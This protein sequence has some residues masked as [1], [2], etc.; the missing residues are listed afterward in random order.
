MKIRTVSILAVLMS[1][2][3][4]AQQGPYHYPQVKKVNQVD[5][6]FGTKIADPFRW[7]E[8]SD[9]PDTRA[10]IDAQNALTFG[11]LKQIPERERISKRLW[12]LW[13]YERYGIPSREGRWYVFTKNTGKQNQNVVYRAASLD[14]PAEVLIDPNTLS[15]DGTVALGPTAFSD[16]GKF[17]AYAVSAAGSDW[18]EWRVRD[19]A[20]GQDL[21]DV[22]KWSKF[23]GASWLKD[24]SG[25]YYGRYEAP[26][27]ANLLQA[28]NKNQKLYFHAVGTPQEKDA[29]VYERP[30]KPDWMFGGEVTDDGRYLLL[31]QTEGTENKNR[32]FVRDL[33]DPNGRIEP[34]LNEFD[35]AYSVVGNDADSFYVLT[36]NGA[37]RYKL[38]AISR[39]NPS[40]AAWRTIIPEAP[41]TDVLDGVTMV[42]DRFVTS[43]MTDAHTA[44]RIYSRA[45]EKLADL[46]LPAIGTVSAFSG[47][48]SHTEGFYAFTSYT[49]PT[50]VYRY[51]FSTGASTVFKRPAV[52]FDAAKYETVQVFYPS[53]DGTK[54]PMF[55]T[56]R[57]GL[58][59][60]GQ[61]PTYL[62]GYGGFNSPVTPSFSPAMA[63]WLEMGGIYAVANLRGGGEYG[64]AWYDA[65][66]L[67]NKQNVFDDFIAAAEYLIRERYTS[68]PKLAIAGGSNGG[69]LV[70]ACMTQRPDLFGAALPAVGVMDMLRYHKFTIGWAWT[71]DYGDPDTKDGFDINIK[72]SP[73]HNIRPG[74]KYPAT[75]VTT[76]DHDDRVVPAHSF[77][78]I[79]TL[80]AAQAGPA[81]IL[82]RIETKAGHGAG[83]P[84]DKQIEERTD[85]FGFLVRELT[86]ALPASFGQK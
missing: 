21:P 41:G 16:D 50:T 43:W 7:L 35:A 67:K 20:T 45:G 65:G 78:F 56:Y 17:M 68:T 29:L 2:T 25:F 86:I 10:W 46:A 60:T 40:P 1:V 58:A 19:V 22:I 74:T 26:K 37:P 24:G 80:Q 5:D 13:D 11:Y 3:L 77:K 27:D 15:K 34:F 36:N 73:L 39:S 12:A 44:M 48:R 53:K 49:Y 70:G 64:Q 81:P 59:K 66:R 14:A 23:S 72:Y 18:Q 54:I 38:V 42:N 52:D 85:I 30:D 47:R 31:Y 57:K 62:Y 76:A 69:L 63:A 51:D 71:S 75:L 32:I 61:N 28:V 83:K 82:I 9:A 55:L 33:K 79:A 4:A 8:D 84:T 6:F